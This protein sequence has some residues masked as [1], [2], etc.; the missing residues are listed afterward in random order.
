MSPAKLSRREARM[1]QIAV[2]VAEL[3]DR[4]T[5]WAEWANLRCLP[6]QAVRNVCK[7][8]GPCWTG[9][10]RRAADLIL[11]DARRPDSTKPRPPSRELPQAAESG[12]YPCD[13][14]SYNANEGVTPNAVL[15]LPPN[16]QT[17]CV[18]AC[19]AHVIEHLWS[20][21]IWTSGCCCGHGK[22]LPS[23]VLSEGA[24]SIPA[25]FA[26]IAEVDR[27]EWEVMRWQL[28]TYREGDQ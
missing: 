4:G 3:E 10:S 20:R 12:L 14:W 2:A 13:C 15:T 11:S 7:G 28:H 27:R 19:I 17:V 5:C 8:R 25:V 16:G 26:A 23:V 1:A 18:D 24:Q 9:E 6:L 22:Q 21:R